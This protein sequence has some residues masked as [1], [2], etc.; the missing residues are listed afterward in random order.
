MYE[1]LEKQQTKFIG[2]TT[3]QD[4]VRLKITLDV[5]GDKHGGWE[6]SRLHVPRTPQHCLQIQIQMRPEHTGTRP[7][8][9]QISEI[10][11]PFMVSALHC[12]IPK[13][14]SWF[15]SDRDATFQERA[16]TSQAPSGT[17]SQ[18][19]QPRKDI[20]HP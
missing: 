1:G 4:V 15:Q 10:G 6:A 8:R 13:V 11:M 20:G 5:L 7:V 9:I 17:Q 12:I 16:S 2:R 18:Y 3:D 19:G 14:Y